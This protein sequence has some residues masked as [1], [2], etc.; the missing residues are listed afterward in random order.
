M[1]MNKQ[2][3]NPF[4]PEYAYIPDGEP[5]VFGD[6]VYLFGSHDKEGGDSFCMLDYE[7]WS[8]P[9]DDLRA[10]ESAGI[11]YSAKQDPLYGEKRPY[12]YAPDVVQGN[13]GRF[14]LYY[15]LAGWKGEGGY[16]G[17]I[18]VAVCDTPNGKYEYLGFVRNPDGT[19]FDE[20]VVFDPA[21]I[22]D[23][24]VI[25]MYCGTNLYWGMEI[26]KWNQFLLAPMAS[27]TYHRPKEQFTADRNPLG[28]FT[29]ELADDMLTVRSK[30][31]KI[32]PLPTR[33][34]RF[35]GHSFYEGA[36]IR[37]VGD[38]YYFIYSSEKNHELCYAT[39][40]FPDRGFSYG[41]T[42][43]STGDV[44]MNGRKDKD[45][46]NVTG[47]THGSIECI[48]GQWYVFY[49]RLSHGSDYSRQACAEPITIAPDGSICQV[50]VSSC[51]LNNGPLNPAG[52]IPATKACILSNGKMPHISNKKWDKPIP[53]VTHHGEKHFIT[54]LTNVCFAGFKRFAFT[55]EPVRL[56]V[57]IRAAGSGKL[58][59]YTD[60]V[61]MKP[62]GL[63]D[64]V[65]SGEWKIF[66]TDIH[67]LKGILP[68]YLRYEGE[69]MI[70][71]LQLSFQ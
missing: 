54:N 66:A 35:K 51:G 17:P 9:V 61:F 53:M 16:D 6:R 65:P 45:R 11:I 1:R 13:D 41:G 42:I 10:W 27:V 49:H 59:I 67:S 52:I 46:M 39:S 55:G 32:L 36:S 24:G 23:D 60:D 18:S 31:K 21:L 64:V 50:E 5:H 37:K 63:I 44:G 20:C 12:M 29:V 26:R 57:T 38:T 19:P 2:I 68:L 58:G 34:N 70:E 25:R 3:F 15:C 56:S 47:T 40:K 14:Y 69:G 43:V 8:A 30:A 22:N 4:L 28:A 33:K 48:A 7:G 62:I 71:L